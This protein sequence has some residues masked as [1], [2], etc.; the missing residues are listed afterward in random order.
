MM[1]ENN[2]SPNINVTT[3]RFLNNQMV[4]QELKIISEMKK[5]LEELNNSFFFFFYQQQIWTKKWKAG[6]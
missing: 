2:V 1:Y 5:S 6:H 4:I 3:Y